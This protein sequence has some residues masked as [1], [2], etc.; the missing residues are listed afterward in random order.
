MFKINNIKGTL[1]I[2]SLFIF[3]SIIY[4]NQNN[5]T[6][7]LLNNNL[8]SKMMTNGNWNK[9]KIEE[10]GKHIQN[11]KNELFMMKYGYWVKTCDS[12]DDLNK[13]YA[14]KQWK[15]SIG[16]SEKN[17][18]PF[19][20][21]SKSK[22]PDIILQKKED[23]P[24]FDYDNIEYYNNT[25]NGNNNGNYEFIIADMNDNNRICYK[26]IDYILDNHLNDHY[27]DLNT[28][29][30][31]YSSIEIVINS[32]NKNYKYNLI[33]KQFD[34]KIKSLESMIYLFENM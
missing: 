22:Y 14:I 30:G 6:I 23:P 20:Y 4:T 29:N 5:L 19:E 16:F 9:P 18:A 33:K 28:P 26:H 13:E 34:M 24:H 21:K 12:L 17:Y 11:M 27:F 15:L 2:F 7:D 32:D 10:K 1:F 25:N 31:P 8:S 3:V